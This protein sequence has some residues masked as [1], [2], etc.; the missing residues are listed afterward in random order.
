VLSVLDGPR[1]ASEKRCDKLGSLGI[2]HLGLAGPLDERPR[3]ALGACAFFSCK[4]FSSTASSEL[5]RGFQLSL[6]P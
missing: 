2:A 4:P 5:A 6:T 3:A 1:R